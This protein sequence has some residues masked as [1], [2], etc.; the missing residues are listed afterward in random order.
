MVEKKSL[1]HDRATNL[2]YNKIDHK[3]NGANRDK[4]LNCHILILKLNRIISKILQFT[5]I[6]KCL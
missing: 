1:T 4:F 3:I 6:L 5:M 2:V